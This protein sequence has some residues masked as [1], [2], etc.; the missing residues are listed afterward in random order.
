LGVARVAVVLCRRRK[1]PPPP[2][3][4]HTHTH[5]Y[6]PPPPIHPHESFDGRSHAMRGAALFTFAIAFLADP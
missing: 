1:C 2:P 4:T 3:N 6:T 5:T